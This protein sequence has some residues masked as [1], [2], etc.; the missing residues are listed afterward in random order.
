MAA[1]GRWTSG[2]GAGELR[3]VAKGAD[4]PA[5][6]I[7]TSFDVRTDAGGRDPDKFSPRLRRYHQLLWSK[8]LP[9]GAVF[10]LDITTHS[11]YLHHRSCLG[12]FWLTSDSII[13]TFGGWR[14]VATI[15]SQLDPGE[16]EEFTHAGYTIGGMMIFPG[17]RVDGKMTINGARGF[18]RRV[19][20]RMDLTLE[21]I[22]RHYLDQGSPLAATLAR[23]SDFFS[24]F[25]DFRGYC[26]FFLLQDLL[27]H[28]GSVDFFVPFDDF[29]LSA[30]PRDVDAYRR[31]RDASV[32]FIESR[33]TRISLIEW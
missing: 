32:R 4:P 21:C 16:L 24:L 27:R 23:Y 8:P 30:F 10:D 17:H 28:D 29:E 9:G 18:L 1:E 20:D 19:A 25:R 11:A 5:G 33:N 6:V 31:Y 26:D 7:D 12:E 13:P 3:S 15:L 22:R 2:N 14:E